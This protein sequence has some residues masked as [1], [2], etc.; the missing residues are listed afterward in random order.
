MAALV[1]GHKWVEKK[2]CNDWDPGA[3]YGNL[4]KQNLAE[5]VS[6]WL[7]RDDTYSEMVLLNCT[8]RC[9]RDLGRP[10]GKG[11][12]TYGSNS[13][14]AYDRGNTGTVV[15]LICW[16]QSFPEKYVNFFG[17]WIMMLIVKLQKEINKTSMC[18]N[19]MHLENSPVGDN[20]IFL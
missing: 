10:D 20:Q 3:S 17:S 4:E 14:N 15:I 13:K 9:T 2:I 6:H 12:G 1:F 16:C 8:E 5:H 19:R 11:G 7:V 18:K